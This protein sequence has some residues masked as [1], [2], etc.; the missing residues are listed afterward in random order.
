MYWDGGHSSC[1]HD[2]E[3]CL[4]SDCS[5]HSAPLTLVLSLGCGKWEAQ[6]LYMG[7]GTEKNHLFPYPLSKWWIGSWVNRSLKLRVG[8]RII[9]GGIIW[10][11]S[12]IE[13]VDR[14]FRC[15]GTPLK[16]WYRSVTWLLWWALVWLSSRSQLGCMPREIC[17]VPE[18]KML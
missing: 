6:I 1:W 7:C 14:T 8:S 2:T 18:L 5:P 9:K 15:K 3:R 17:L 11:T 16:C 10:I 12:V 4:H 13:P